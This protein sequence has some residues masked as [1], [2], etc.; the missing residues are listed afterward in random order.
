VTRLP[1][2]TV[3][4]TV[5]DL[6]EAA[7]A[8][9]SVRHYEDA[10]LLTRAADLIEELRAAWRRGTRPP[11]PECNG[12]ST[13]V[14]EVRRSKAGPTR[15]RHE[16]NT[17]RC[18]WTLWDGVLDHESIVKP[19]LA[20]PAP[21]PGVLTCLS[22]QHWTDDRCGMGFPDPE[23]EGVGFAADCETFLGAPLP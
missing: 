10:A 4:N 14:V 21:A 13:G 2:T 15:R 18:R 11:C 16:C 9:A 5:A 17:C 19:T 8:A 7:Q 1:P 23:L 6:R 3:A 22:C 12:T 20:L